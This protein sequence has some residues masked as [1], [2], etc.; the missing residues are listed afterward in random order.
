MRSYGAGVT[1]PAGASTGPDDAETVLFATRVGS[2]VRSAL[3]S[4]VLVVGIAVLAATDPA[5]WVAWVLLVTQL[6]MAVIRWLVVREARR[7]PWS[8]RVAASGVCWRPEGPSLP[9]ASVA[10]IEIRRARGLRRLLPH[11]DRL[12]L[13]NH[14][15]ADFAR[16]AKTRPLG[17]AV[18][19]DQV[20]ATPSE[21]VAVFRRFTDAPVG[22]RP[23]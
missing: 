10:S 12:L 13:V 14:V 15:E 3:A 9:W 1:L 11:G 8:L 4:S 22:G 16:R 7:Q 20:R 2:R 5:G 23:S 21:L 18:L 6:P 19:L 17:R